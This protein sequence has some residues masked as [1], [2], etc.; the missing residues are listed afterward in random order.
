MKASSPCFL[1]GTG[2][3]AKV[4]H[5]AWRRAGGE[6]AG[7]FDDAAEGSRP[8]WRGLRVRRFGEEPERSA[9]V[10]IAIGNNDV[11]KRV[12]TAVRAAGWDLLTVVHPAAVIDET[13]QIASGTFAAA[14][15]IIAPDARVGEGV[16][17]NH[18]AIVDHDCVIGAWAHVAPGAVL[19][20]G[21]QVGEGTLIG[22]GAVVMPGRK[23]GNH[24]TVGAG[25]VVTRDVP[26]GQTMIGVPA[27][28]LPTGKR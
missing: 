14:G 13:A 8:P 1:Y 20:G 9:L 23:V 17:V 28:Q 11:R 21:V 10:H 6:W 5:A 27:A 12:A 25:A 19:G 22:A 26:E 16:I 2:G 4:V 18:L 15:C 7:C 3:H 24:A